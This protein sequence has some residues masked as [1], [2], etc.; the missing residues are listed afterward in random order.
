MGGAEHTFTTEVDPVTG[1]TATTERDADGNIV[2]TT[3]TTL[4]GNKT[5]EF[6]PDDAGDVRV[7]EDGTETDPAGVTHTFHIERVKRADGSSSFSGTDEGDDGS[8]SATEGGQDAD[9]NASF[10]DRLTKADGSVVLTTRTT[11][12]DGHGTE[13]ITVS[14]PDG[15]VV[16]DNTTDF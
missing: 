1:T 10:T 13:H 8:V 3:T 12:A 15:T 2:S 9:G 16:S 7:V 5:V 4:D 6:A 11:D 14:D